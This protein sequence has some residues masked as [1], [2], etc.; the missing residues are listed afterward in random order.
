MRSSFGK[1]GILKKE[2]FQGQHFVPELLVRR[3]LGFPSAG[4][5]TNELIA[6]HGVH[7]EVYLTR[8]S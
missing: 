6:K 1:F 3:E 2:K 5:K 4:A 7:D 8:R